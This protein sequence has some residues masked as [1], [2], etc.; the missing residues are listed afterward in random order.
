[1]TFWASAPYPAA[2][3]RLREEARVRMDAVEFDPLQDGTARVL[4]YVA[5]SPFRP[6]AERG[7]TVRLAKAVPRGATPPAM[8]PRTGA[9]GDG[10][11][12]G[13]RRDPRRARERRV[14][15]ASR[16]GR[17]LG[18]EQAIPAVTPARALVQDALRRGDGPTDD[19]G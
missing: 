16:G 8:A 10:R 1:L 2:L 4:A 9:R 7:E 19:A 11:S 3:D 5:S 13:G 15:R 18:P 6:R 14:V 17:D 12:R